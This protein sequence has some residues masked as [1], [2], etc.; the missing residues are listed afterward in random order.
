MRNDEQSD[1]KRHGSQINWLKDDRGRRFYIKQSGEKVYYD[2]QERDD[3][4]EE[5]YRPCAEQCC[6]TLLARVA[7]HREDIVAE[8][9]RYCSQWGIDKRVDSDTLARWEEERF[10]ERAYPSAHQQLLFY[11]KVAIFGDPYKRKTPEPEAKLTPGLTNGTA[12]SKEN[13]NS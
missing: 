1:G 7:Y 2:Q 9:Q 8:Y 10:G 6:S 12:T 5:Q 4:M 13:V 3:A 11:V